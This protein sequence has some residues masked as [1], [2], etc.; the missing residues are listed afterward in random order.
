MQRSRHWLIGSAL[1]CLV[2][3]TIAVLAD[4][5]MPPAA[6]PPAPLPLPPVGPAGLSPFEE[7]TATPAAA[8]DASALAAA[9]EPTALLSAETVP[10]LGPSTDELQNLF[11]DL[12]SRPSADPE[13]DRELLV[14]LGSDVRQRLDE[15]RRQGHDASQILQLE[16]LASRIARQASIA[17]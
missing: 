4:D 9:P 12:H 8:V 14:A 1:G 15:L 10:T 17:P 16:R 3:A 7:A 2:A 6:P 13:L 11:E 5:A